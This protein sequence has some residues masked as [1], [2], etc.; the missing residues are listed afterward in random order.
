MWE[1]LRI[2]MVLLLMGFA[3]VFAVGIS[4]GV[5][6][7]IKTELNSRIK[8]LE[9]RIRILEDNQLRKEIKK[10]SSLQ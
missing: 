4:S 6:N 1:I 3:C 8:H 9:M 10:R 5:A 7:S 2:I